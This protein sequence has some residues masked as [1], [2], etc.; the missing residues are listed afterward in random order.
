ML[1]EKMPLLGQ[2]LTTENSCFENY[3]TN[4]HFTLAL[5]WKLL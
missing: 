4:V 3:T 5:E 2:A 1:F